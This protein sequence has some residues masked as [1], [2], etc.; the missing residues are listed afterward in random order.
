MFDLLSYTGIIASI[1]IVVGIYIASLYYPNYSHTRQFCSELGAFGSPTQRLSPA[2]NNYPLGLLFVLF[3]YYLIAAN[4]SNLL[5]TSLNTTIIGIMVIV[6]GV[7]T[8]VCGFFPMDADPYTPTPTASCKIHTWSGLIMLISFIVAPAIVML[9]SV[10]PIALR[11]FSFN[12]I[13]GCFFYSY[14][15]SGAL[16]AKTHP[17]LYQRLSYGFQI[18]WLFV[19]S[20]YLIG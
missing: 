5:S 4:S 17:G 2:I 6:H 15:L 10:Y 8:W 3:G 13:L 9:S 7:C 11:L 18:L 1:W 12:C 20:L 19:Y 14:K 16:K